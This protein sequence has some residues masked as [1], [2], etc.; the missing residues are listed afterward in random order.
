MTAPYEIPKMFPEGVAIVVGGSGG[1]GGA[2]AQ[3]LAAHGSPVVLTYR[4]S[5]ES[6]EGY[7]AA[8]RAAGGDADVL[9]LDALD[10][11]SVTLFLE[12]VSARGSIHSLIFATGP[13]IYLEPIAKSDI[14]RLRSYIDA[15]V[16][17]F[18]N[19]I[20]LALPYLRKSHGS[21]TALVTCGV[22]HWLP[23]DILSIV[24]K[25]AVWSLIQGLAKEEGKRGVR[26]N[27]IG[28]G[29]I[30]AGM[31]IRGKAEGL[32]SDD[33]FDGVAKASALRRIGAATDIAE[34][35]AYLAS[36]RAAFITGQLVNVDGGLTL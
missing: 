27:A 19:V 10:R 13:H 1:L 4:N 22:R 8:I 24:P 17:G 35:A 21:I 23:H 9:R 36:Q 34:T 30:D 29:V 20:Q 5:R 3:S 2:I 16:I 7:A 25:A 31:T 18:A 32:F 11:E 33:F 26:A 12:Q 28:V 15:D 14:A 6:A